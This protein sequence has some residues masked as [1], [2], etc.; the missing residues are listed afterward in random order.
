MPRWLLL[1][2]L[3]LDV[4][5][6]RET[7]P[8]HVTVEEVVAKLAPPL[9]AVAVVE[10][11]ASGG[12]RTAVLRPEVDRPGVVPRESL[13]TPPPSTVRLRVTVPPEA[14]LRFG[15]G[16][17]GPKRHERD[18]SGVE[19]LVTVDG[20][21]RFRTALN[22]AER[23][24]HRA[25]RE[26]SVDLRREQ[27][28]MVELA[29][30]TRAEDPARPLAGT[31]GWSHVRLL[32]RTV[33]ERQPARPDAP[34]LLIVLVDTLR[35]DRLG[36]YGARPSP[37]PTLDRLAA[38]GLVFEDSVSQ[39]SWTL[40]SVAS[41]FTG[42]HPRSHG[43]ATIAATGDDPT[44]GGGFLADGLVT[45]AEL[46]RGAGITTVGISANPLVGRDS[47]LAQGFEAFESFA[48]DP[49][50]ED[51]HPASDVNRRFLDWLARHRAW[52]FV[53][54]LQYMEP[55]DPYDPPPA[56]RH[57]SA[58][59]GLR[60]TLA[61]GRI[62]RLAKAIN[63]GQAEPFSAVEIEHL[64]Q[65]YD[66]E[67]RA[68]DDAFAALL[69]DLDHAGLLDS[70]LI[71]VT[72]DHGEEFQEHGRLKHGSHL[73]EES[74]RVP[75]VIVGP[76]IPAGRR[77]D[78][79]QGI[80][81]LPTVSGLLGLD[82]PPGLPGRDLLTTRESRDAF[83][84]TGMGITPDG[85]MTDVIALRTPRWKLIRTPEIDR[86]E[87]Y[88]LARD[89]LELASEPV[90]DAATT[91]GQRLERWIASAPSAPDANG[92]DPTLRAKLR[93]LGYAD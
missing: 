65:L 58:P 39:S 26:G 84:E 8:P 34:N 10:G 77:A 27:G 36:I 75:L 55:H 43:A 50:T 76:G 51:W 15:V 86:V 9:P 87:L 24:S 31:P 48:W 20:D 61:R 44:T 67:I 72:A 23:S 21:Q 52:R 89:R 88:D 66:G 54:W 14:E 68:W 63:R 60:P 29:L 71:V 6:Q 82:P 83:A 70:T 59:P 91:L 74:I 37:S 33:R 30:V 11:P 45:W 78:L 22:P 47:N 1:A 19:F 35:A 13:V 81:L 41:L 57:G 42:L 28:R 64:R 12:V 16:V 69:R 62:S 5:C 17:D 38:N 85:G 7:L 56:Y 80:D 49:R 53:A 79:A 93:A 18:R 46:A 40:P 92:T 2:T 25:W 3:V 73:Y 90:A 32:R 4:A